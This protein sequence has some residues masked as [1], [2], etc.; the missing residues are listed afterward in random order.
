ML[1]LRIVLSIVGVILMP[2]MWLRS[3]VSRPD[4][5]TND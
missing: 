3:L 1:I 5:N 4:G 2:V